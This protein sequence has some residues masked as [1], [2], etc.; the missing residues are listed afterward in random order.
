MENGTFRVR[1]RR[2]GD[3]PIGARWVL[4]VKRKADGSIERYKGRVVAKGYSQ[5]PGFDY[6]ETF[7]PTAKWAALRAIFAIAALRDMEIESVDIS[8]AF[9]NGDL[10]EDI[11]MS[12]FEGLRDMR[13]D[14]FK[15]GGPKHDSDWVL[16]LNKALY[17]LKQSP[18]MWHQKL[19]SAMT[20]MGFRLVECDNSIWV[21][22][23]GK[24][25][26]IVPEY[27]DDITIVA[28]LKSDVN[29]VKDEL[30]KRFKL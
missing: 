19:N 23:K 28:E 6:T 13:P 11:T 4:R 21:F 26:V 27:V 29:W 22:L 16:E 30:K 14:L 8:S 12:V 25:R 5:R 7:A 9:L 3:K 2:P 24:T 18:R 20:E 17:G 15:K 10:E 1:E